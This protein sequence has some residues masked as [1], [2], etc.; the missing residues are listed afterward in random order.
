MER[1]FFTCPKTDRRIDIGFETEIGTLLR[2]RSQIV[3]AK[4]PACGD[5]HEW[6]VADAWLAQAA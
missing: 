6:R 2:I 5:V 4:C 3:R 1:L